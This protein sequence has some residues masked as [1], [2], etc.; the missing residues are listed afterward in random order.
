MNFAASRFF[1]LI[2]PI[3]NLKNSVRISWGKGLFLQREAADDCK[4][5]AIEVEF[6]G[7]LLAC[8]LRSPAP[9]MATKIFDQV[10]WL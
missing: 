3:E 8:Y 1:M 6:N 4:G 7:N 9:C 2:A 5:T 10:K